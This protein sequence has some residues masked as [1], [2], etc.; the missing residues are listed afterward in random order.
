MRG[1][2]YYYSYTPLRS[3]SFSFHLLLIKRSNTAIV[4]S[5]K[6]LIEPGGLTDGISHGTLVMYR[7]AYT[8]LDALHRNTNNN[9]TYHLIKK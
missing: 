5:S 7:Q 8:H 6:Q 2:V 3:L 1:F 4:P 9:T